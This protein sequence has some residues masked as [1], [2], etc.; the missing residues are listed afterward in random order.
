[1]PDDSAIAARAHALYLARVEI[2]VDG[3]PDDDWLKAEEELFHYQMGTARH[4]PLPEAI[5]EALDGGRSDTTDPKTGVET[6]TG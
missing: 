4:M 1:M 2:G 5:R 3:T 6:I